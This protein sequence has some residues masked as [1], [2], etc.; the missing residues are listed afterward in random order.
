MKSIVTLFIACLTLCTQ[1]FAQW[2]PWVEQN[3]G[4]PPGYHVGALHAVDANVVWGIGWNHQSP[5]HYFIRT[6]DGGRHGPATQS[7]PLRHPSLQQGSL[8]SMTKKLWVVMMNTQAGVSYQSGGLFSTIDG[9]A[10][11]QKD[12][13]AFTTYGGAGCFVHFFDA[14]NGVTVGNPDLVGGY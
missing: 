1:G 4:L 6:T 11:W 12:T 13:T 3:T 9:G 2:N 8:E 5:S 7:L 10:T 14:N